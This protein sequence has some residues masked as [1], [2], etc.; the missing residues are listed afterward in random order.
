MF[1]VYIIQSKIIERY[2]IGHTGD[3]DK[4]IKEH[5]SGKSKST[6]AY[7]PWTLAY[8]EICT[9]KSE[10]FIR[11][12]EIKSFKSG[13]KFQELKKSESWQSG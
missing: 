3:L 1:Y 12:K 9:T 4:R 5:N 11:E 6:K 2:Y 10:A 7:R 13:Y 8:F